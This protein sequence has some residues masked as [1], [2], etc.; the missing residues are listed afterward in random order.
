[1]QQLPDHRP[2]FHENSRIFKNNADEIHA[3]DQRN[4]E[5]GMHVQ[6]F[7]E[8]NII[9]RG[10]GKHY[11]ED[12]CLDASLG[13]V[14]I[15][16]P[17]VRHGYTGGDGFDVFHVLISHQFI[18]RHTTDFQALPAFFILFAAEPL[19]RT[20]VKK[21]LH[22]KLSDEQFQKATGI[23]YEMRTYNRTNDPS[24]CLIRSGMALVLI[25]LLCR[26]YTENEGAVEHTESH[27]NQSFMKALSVIHERYADKLTIEGL[28][29]IAHL[30]RSAFIRKFQTICKMPPAEYIA[31]RRIE[32]AEHL[33]TQTGLSIFEIASRT[34]FYDTSH[35]NKIFSQKKGCSPS[36]Y[37]KNHAMR[38]REV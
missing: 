34:G 20:N 27:E 35:F 38:E 31:N 25:T 9:T 18:E 22:L 17:H 24:D 5:I 37:R 32:A 6:D 3:F 2:Y 21:R 11:I 29:D 30:S 7:F 1:M 4:Y 23:L 33:L 28:A 36:L 10:K 8:I 15:L 14:F 12:N 13:D 26:I 19:M 16:P